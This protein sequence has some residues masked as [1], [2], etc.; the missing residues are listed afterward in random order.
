[1]GQTSFW[2]KLRTF[3]SWEKKIDTIKKNPEALSEAS[4][5]VGLEV[6]PKKTRYKVMSRYQK[7]GKT[8]SIKTANRLFEDVA[9]FKYPGTTLTDQSACTKR[10]RAD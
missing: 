2:P 1:M 9:E 5:E 6:N 4:K 10:L 7:A 8:H 3:I